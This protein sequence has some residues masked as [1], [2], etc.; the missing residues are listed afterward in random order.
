MKKLP[1][2]IVFALSISTLFAQYQNT[3]MIPD[4]GAPGMNVYIEIIAPPDAI[5][6]F[7]NTMSLRTERDSDRG[8]IDFSPVY[9]SW[10]GRML[11]A[12]IF[13]HPDHPNLKPNSPRWNEGIHIPVA[14]Y[15]GNNFCAKYDFYVVQPFHIGH[16]TISMGLLLVKAVS[17][18]APQEE[19]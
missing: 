2:I 7:D 14:L 17:E 8:K 4:I 6:F 18:Y 9:A 12:Q 19:Q 13:V 1:I 16:A 3:Y 10:S 11:S 15:K 5:G